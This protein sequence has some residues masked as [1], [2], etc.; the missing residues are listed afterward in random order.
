MALPGLNLS[1]LLKFTPK[2]RDQYFDQYARHLPDVHVKKGHTYGI[3]VGGKTLYSDDTL[4]LKV[5]FTR[6]LGVKARWAR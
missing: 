6:L 4:D 3:R 2:E 5:K 1:E